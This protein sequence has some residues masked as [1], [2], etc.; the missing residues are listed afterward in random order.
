VP[1]AR[2][3]MSTQWEASGLSIEISTFRLTA[4]GT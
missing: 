3:K 1:S 4:S 2:T